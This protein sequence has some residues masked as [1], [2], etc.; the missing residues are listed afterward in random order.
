M[1]LRNEL[2][3]WHFCNYLALAKNAAVS[4]IWWRNMI[5]LNLALNRYFKRKHKETDQTPNFSRNLH[6]HRCS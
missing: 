1:E 5:D 3:L 6:V 2:S 4:I